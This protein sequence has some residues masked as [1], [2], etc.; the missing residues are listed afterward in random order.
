M[1]ETLLVAVVVLFALLVGALLPVL[2]S[3]RSFLRRTER[4]VGSLERLAGETLERTNTILGRVD[5]LARE[6][7]AGSP[8]LRN[9]VAVVND[10]SETL[11]RTEKSLR[12]FLAVGA[13][14]GPAVAAFVRTMR[15]DG[16][17]ANAAAAADSA[18]QGGAARDSPVGSRP[19]AAPSSRAAAAPADVRHAAP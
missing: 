19:A 6:V 16:P 15:D 3:V 4:A 1:N 14:V 10:L 13:S 7:E 17:G 18:A 8:G 2:M 11:M 5:H 9:V 12:L